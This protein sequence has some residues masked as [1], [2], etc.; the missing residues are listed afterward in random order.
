MYVMF[1]KKKEK[2][3]SNINQTI[4]DLYEQYLITEKNKQ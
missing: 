1:K 2:D 3:Y 4:V